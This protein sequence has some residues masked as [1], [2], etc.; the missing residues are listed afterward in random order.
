MNIS[1]NEELHKYTNEDNGKELISTTTL[2][3]LAGI[4]PNYSAVNPEVL[5]AKAERGSM[6]HKEIEEYSK[7]H[8]MGFTREVQEFAKYIQ[9]HNLTVIASE[10]LVANDSVAGTIDLVL[11]DNNTQE[12]ILVDV[13]T[14]STIHNDSVA[15][16]T[17]IYRDL[18]EYDGEQPISKLAVFHFDKEGNLKVKEVQPKTKK[19]VQEL[20]DWYLNNTET[21]VP[22]IDVDPTEL[23]KL[24]EAQKIIEKCELELKAAQD[25]AKAV[26]EAIIEAMKYNGVPKYEDDK[27]VITYIA[28]TTSQVI[29]SKRLKEEQPELYNKYI[30][31][32][33]KS[34][35]VRIKLKKEKEN[36]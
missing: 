36:E 35:S 1:Y 24:V 33:Q 19:A 30:K 16:Q 32:T 31:V 21:F 6:I 20:F 11:I 23:A 26:R 17:S 25:N 34:E 4:S 5:K 3:K 27:I 8:I 29:D 22:S 28:P 15:W 14:T 2:L 10:R 13:K 12:L 18:W 7:E 9:E